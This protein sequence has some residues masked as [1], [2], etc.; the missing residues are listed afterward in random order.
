MME[1]RALSRNGL[2][3]KASA[4]SSRRLGLVAFPDIR[5]IGVFCNPRVG[6]HRPADLKAVQPRDQDVLKDRHVRAPLA[7]LVER[8]GVA[9]NRLQHL[10]AWSC[11]A[12]ASRSRSRERVVGDEHAVRCGGRG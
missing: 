2:A 9:V 12:L 10:E 6:P 11:S 8:P 1:S 3:R 5:M 4:P 7:D